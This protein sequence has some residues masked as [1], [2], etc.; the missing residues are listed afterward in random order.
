MPPY[1]TVQDKKL[2]TAQL[3]CSDLEEK[4]ILYSIGM[5]RQMTERVGLSAQLY[6]KVISQI[7]KEK[8]EIPHI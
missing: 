4:E 5:W 8:K 2:P 1:R 6:E 3:P 7:S